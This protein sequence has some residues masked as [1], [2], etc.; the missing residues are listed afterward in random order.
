MMLQGRASQETQGRQTGRTARAAKNWSETMS[1][2]LLF[3]RRMRYQGQLSS[4][5][6]FVVRMCEGGASSS[7]G[8]EGLG[9]ARGS[10]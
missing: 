7:T 4:R 2:R 1:S 10:R 8:G 5:I 6:C 3:L 9:W